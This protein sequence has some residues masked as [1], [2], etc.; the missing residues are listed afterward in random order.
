MFIPIL[1]NTSH[2]SSRVALNP[3]EASRP[4]PW[5]DCFI[6]ILSA[7]EGRCSAGPDGN[8]PA[9]YEA[10][11]KETSRIH[12]L[13]RADRRR[14]NEIYESLHPGQIPPPLYPEPPTLDLPHSDTP[15]VDLHLQEAGSPGL[16]TEPTAVVDH[17]PIPDSGSPAD[18]EEDED[19][20]PVDDPV[21]DIFTELVENRPPETMAVFLTSFDISSVDTVNDP[22]LFFQELET[23]YK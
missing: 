21:A 1:P 19:S 9:Q 17:D 13:L 6:S 10:A 12:R 22:Q 7:I 23:L 18:L 16:G 8:E 14:R 20:K 2:P 15:V 3:S 11:I 4:F 5:D